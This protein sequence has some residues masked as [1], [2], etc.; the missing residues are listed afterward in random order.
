MKEPVVFDSTCLIRLQRIRERN[1]LPALFDP[2]MIP[3]QVER[4]FG[5]K[6]SW[7]QI[8]NLRPDVPATA[9]RLVVDSGEAEA[10]A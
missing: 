3:P 1:I 6:F 9:L 8:E 5:S 10:I 2:V 7:L 4:E